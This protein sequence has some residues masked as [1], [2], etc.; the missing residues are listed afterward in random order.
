MRKLFWGLT[1]VSVAAVG[2]MFWLKWQGPTLPFALAG[3]AVIECCRPASSGDGSSHV[4]ITHWV[5]GGTNQ[6]SANDDDFS[7][8]QK[9]DDPL[10]IT[11]PR[12]P[13]L[14]DARVAAVD[15]DPTPI[16]P[17]ITI[18][19]PIEQG[20]PVAIADSGTWNGEFSTTPGGAKLPASPMVDPALI[21]ANAT[22]IGHGDRQMVPAVMPYCEE[23]EPDPEIIEAPA[24]G[25][26]TMPQ[27]ED[28]D[29]NPGIWSMFF[30]SVLP[31]H[32]C[33]HGGNIPDCCEEPQPHRCPDAGH[34]APSPYTEPKKEATPADA[35]GGDEESDIPSVLHRKT[36]LK[37]LRDHLHKLTEDSEDGPAFPD[38][39]TMEY[40]PSDHKPYE[41]L[42][43][44][45]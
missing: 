11:E 30:P 27:A 6:P 13:V 14:T 32:S 41:H 4:S 17:T 34:A 1:A 16:V 18:R 33:N 22:V 36:S 29:D 23:D 44:P 3:T 26:D 28:G 39:D 8:F 40:R 24:E 20:N 37:A 19:E 25:V 35:P 5:P 42:P 2:G 10:E 21:Q 31:M 45:I 38:V 12:E 7:H 9:P 15:F 43:N